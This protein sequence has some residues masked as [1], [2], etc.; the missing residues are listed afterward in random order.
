MARLLVGLHVSLFHSD[1]EL[2]HG[3][4]FVEGASEL[5]KRAHLLPSRNSVTPLLLLISSLHPPPRRL[6][7]V[8]PQ[9]PVT[10]LSPTQR[11]QRLLRAL[12]IREIRMR[13]P[14]RLARSPINRHPD[15]NHVSDFAEQVIEFA[16]RHV[17]GHVADEEGSGWGRGFGAGAERGGA[18]ALRGV[19][20]GE[21]AAFE[22]LVIVHLDGLGGCLL[23]GE[24]YVAEPVARKMGVSMDEILYEAK[25]YIPFT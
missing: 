24:G 17:E 16:I 1:C 20:D 19:L 13:E 2:L 6:A 25:A 8:H 21:A 3:S 5:R 22:W 4:H 23:G 15:I 7:I 12:N 14:S 9:C 11:Q 18:C 10:D